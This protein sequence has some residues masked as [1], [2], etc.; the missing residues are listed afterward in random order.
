MYVSFPA[1]SVPGIYYTLLQTRIL[2]RI[3]ENLLALPQNSD[4]TVVGSSSLLLS[5]GE[6]KSSPVSD[7]SH[8][9]DLE[10]IHLRG[11]PKDDTAAVEVNRIRDEIERKQEHQNELDQARDKA[12]IRQL[13]M[14]ALNASND[15]EMIRILQLGKHDMPKAIKALLRA[16]ESQ[17]AASFKHP[18]PLMP[19]RNFERLRGLTWP[20]DDREKSA[21]DGD[22]W[23]TETFDADT[24]VLKPRRSCPTIRKSEVT[25]QELIGTGFFSNVYK[26]AWRHRIV[27]I[28][29]L[30]RSTTE[31]AF[32]AEFDIWKSLNN[33]NVLRLYGTSGASANNL[34]W[35]F[36]SPYMRNG[37]LSQY[38]KR[39]E[40]ELE[41]SN[42]NTGFS[43][44][45]ERRKYDL[46]SELLRYMV[47]IARGMEYLHGRQIYHGDLKGTNVLVDNNFRCV[48]A[49]FGHSKWA[50]RV[51][52]NNSKHNHG[53]R[54][55]SP[56]LMKGRSLLTKEN[57]VY[58]YAITLVEILTMGSL[59]WPTLP[60][61][62]VREA[63]LERGERPDYPGD[64]AHSVGI[65]SLLEEC[66]Q[67]PPSQRPAFSEIVQNLRAAPNT[68]SGRTERT[69]TVTS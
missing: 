56:E 22:Y 35:F 28:K 41:S 39:L 64:L 47:D 30:D 19:S 13:L 59:P 38:L 7:V 1:S 5:G 54:W 55:Q 4:A 6:E 16:L 67:N 57:D 34:P 69:T 20:L 25:R 61:D 29:I 63:V 12:E 26:G 24:A 32:M 31:E 21:L 58:A 14:K 18:T 3:L 44:D 23:N 10:G 50:S 33:Q 9:S 53:F 42:G 62:L 68:P 15:K 49:D 48:L 17:Y 40:W 45:P 27:A 11:F 52:Y 36:V 2:L 60:D 8:D 43:S 66:W 46:A 65:R 51:T 37:S